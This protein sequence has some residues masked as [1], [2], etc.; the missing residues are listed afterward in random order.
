MTSLVVGMGIGQLYKSVLTELGHDVITVDTDINK[1]ADYTDIKKALNDHKH[2]STVNICTPNFTHL[3]IARTIAKHADIVFIEKPGLE[4]AKQW[5]H[6]CEE[7][8]T[9]RFMMVKNNQYR[10][11]IDVLTQLVSQASIINLSWTNNDRVPYPGTWFTTNDLAYGG[12]SRDLLPHLLSMFQTLSGFSHEEASIIHKQCIQMWELKDLTSTDYG[13]ININGIYDVDDSV[14]INFK[15]SKGRT[16]FLEAN[17]RCLCEDDRSILIIF[18]DGKRYR[19]DLG[20]CPED[21]YKRMI[22]TAIE[23]RDVDAYWHQQYQLDMWIHT[24][25]EDMKIDKI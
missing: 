15:D 12:V 4:T 10:D 2:F 3:L 7:F 1:G 6:L 19:Y 22:K 11:N 9:T 21:A 20:L 14:E 5:K 25:I 18:P 8:P 17:W 16:W 13:S 24:I 23:M